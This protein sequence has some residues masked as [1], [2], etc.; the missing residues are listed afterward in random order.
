[1]N[2]WLLSVF[3][4]NRFLQQGCKRSSVWL[5]KKF[6]D[7]HNNFLILFVGFFASFFPPFIYIRRW[8][9]QVLDLFGYRKQQAYFISFAQSIIIST[10]TDSGWFCAT[11]RLKHWD[12]SVNEHRNGWVCLVQLNKILTVLWCRSQ[13]WVSTRL[14]HGWS[15]VATTTMSSSGTLP[16]WTQRCRPSGPYSLVNGENDDW[17]I[18]VQL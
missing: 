13:H 15:P 17:E 3:L 7:L 16:E 6:V 4:P 12:V 5:L 1:M 9:W 14:A 18:M 11:S 2:T 10:N 8:W